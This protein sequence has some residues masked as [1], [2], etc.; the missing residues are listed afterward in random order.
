MKHL[1]S[2][3]L[4]LAV[5]GFL[6]SGCI[7]NAK[8][9]ATVNSY[10]SASAGVDSFVATSVYAG[11]L[12]KQVNDTTTSLVIT[13][14]MVPLGRKIVLTVTKY[15]GLTGNFSIV[16]G[17]AAALYINNTV[18]SALGGV[19][20]VTGVSANT[21]SGYFSFNATNGAVVSSGIFSV[22]N[23]YIYP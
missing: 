18:D 19:V 3:A 14:E 5:A 1:L 20:V 2:I 7:K 21:I 8:N 22:G 11:L 12:D 10:M 16:Q 15:K 17:Q 4:V 13:G 6:F 23:P 9:D